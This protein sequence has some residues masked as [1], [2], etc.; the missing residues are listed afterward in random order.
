MAFT[1]KNTLNPA[2]D[3]PGSSV[4]SLD[5]NLSLEADKSGLE[6]AGQSG[7]SASITG[8]A[9]KAMTIDGL[10]GMTEDSVG[11][12]LTISGAANQDCNGDF[13]ILQY[14]SPTSVKVYNTRGVASDQNN[15]SL[16]WK[17]VRYYTLSD[18]IDYTR[19]DRWAIKGTTNYWDPVPTYQ[20]P[21]AVGVDI[22]V[23]LKNLAGK[24]LD[25]IGFVAPM[26]FRHKQISGGNDKIVIT[27]VGNLPHADAAGNK[28]GVPLF[29]TGPFA[30][31]YESCLA[32]ITFENNENQAQTTDGYTIIGL[33]HG[34]TS[35]SPDSVE[36][37]FYKVK[38]SEGLSTAVPY[39][40][41]N[42]L[43]GYFN[44]EVGF[45]KTLDELD[46]TIFRTVGGLS[47]LSTG[48]SRADTDALQ[49]SIGVQDG[50]A[51]INGHL[52]N[53][54]SNFTFA[55]NPSTVIAALN[56]LN[57]KM[58]DF[59]FTGPI[60]ITGYSVTDGIQQI[61][62]AI[63]VTGWRYRFI[64][65]TSAEIPAFTHHKLPYDQYYIPDPTHQAA[66]LLV[67]VNGYLKDPSDN[68]QEDS[69]KEIDMFHIM[70]YDRVPSNST[71]SYI[72][73][74]PSILE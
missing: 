3:I 61:S 48:D 20:S 33:T 7:S 71:I 25:A 52:N 47:N 23:N 5:R 32:K 41:E 67:F 62:D 57:A 70:F 18:D 37:K 64:E 69:Y 74:R 4:K 15:G 49:K 27:S 63:E 30:G 39:T 1:K 43:D 60:L 13:I 22:D 54:S 55:S 12:S 73:R 50:E 56:D 8:F 24:T 19:I 10:S 28:S 36:V 9:S 40:F 42:G 45:F 21:K 14:L 59:T 72:I 31:R 2:D 17:E 29:D 65:K 16:S 68:F 44:V 35:V 11:N 26:I 53:K 46:E 66:N 51:T 34:G 38:F 58:G 6:L